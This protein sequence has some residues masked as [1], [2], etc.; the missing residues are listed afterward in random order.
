MYMLLRIKILTNARE[1]Q[2]SRSREV[3][4]CIVAKIGR[5]HSTFKTFSGFATIATKAGIIPIPATSRT[6]ETSMRNN[7]TAILNGSPLGKR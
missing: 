7:R 5:S 4:I 2:R 6:A 1:P 3:V